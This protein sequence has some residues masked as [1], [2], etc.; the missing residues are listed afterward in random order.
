MSNELDY[1]VTR[2]YYGTLKNHARLGGKTD[3]GHYEQQRKRL[4]EFAR[5][6]PVRIRIKPVK[7]KRS[8]GDL[9]SKPVKF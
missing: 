7:Q 9:P 6:L 1:S 2:E 4:C 3:V 5:K 8:S